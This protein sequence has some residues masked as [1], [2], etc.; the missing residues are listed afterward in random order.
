[1]PIEK[2][3]APDKMDAP[4]SDIVY[5]KMR[6]SLR[7]G[8]FAPGQRISEAELCQ[9]FQVSRTPVREAV[10][11]LADEGF[12][13]T[14]AS[15]RAVVADIDI[16][17]AEEIYDMR[18]AIECL[19]AKLA[20]KKATTSDILELK[21]ILEE[22]ERGVASEGEFLKINDRFHRAIYRISGNRYIQKTADVLLLSSGMI[23]GNTC[24]RYD[25]E[26]WSLAEHE[27]IYRAIENGD[28]AAAEEAARAHTR[29]GRYQ[30]ISLI[31]S[32]APNRKP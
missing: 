1:M 14:G 21:S 6:E 26:T 13:A 31:A 28:T 8:L 30:R 16:D 24:G 29:R 4:L 15:G 19:A 20:A 17:R 32:G 22:Q 5:A 11:R 2:T 27:A 18:E 3:D 12:L 25:Y 9:T 7:R 10:R 23:R